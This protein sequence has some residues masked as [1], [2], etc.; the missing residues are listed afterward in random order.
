[1][2]NWLLSTKPGQWISKAAA[3]IGAALLLFFFGFRKG[4]QSQKYKQN[5]Q[6][7]KNYEDRAKI[8]DD[9]KKITD[10]AART[11]LADWRMP[12]N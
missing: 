12:D 1:M 7:K 4:F 5:N 11:E 3:I 9:V 8:D 6:V 2:F 10:D